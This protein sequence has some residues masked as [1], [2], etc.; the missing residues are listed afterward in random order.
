MMMNKGRKVLARL[1]RLAGQMELM[2]DNYHKVMTAY[3]QLVVMYGTE[4]CWKGE[5]KPGMSG[6]AGELQKL[7]NQEAR[8]VT[9]CFR[10]TNLGALTMESR[11]RPATAQLDNRQR[12]FT[13]QLLSLPAGSEARGIMGAHSAIGRR[14]EA[15][16]GYSGRVEGTEMV[17]RPVKTDAVRIVEEQ[18]RAI[19]EAE[20]DREGLTIFTNGSRLESGATGYGMAWKAGNRWVGVKAHIGYNQEAFDVECAALARVLEVAARRRTGPKAVTIFTDLQAAM[21]RIASEEPGP[22]QRYVRQTREWIKELR[23]RDRNLRIELHWCPA[24]SGATGNEE[25][26]KWAKQVAE[27]PD[28]QGVEWMDYKDRYGRW[29]MPLPRSLANLKQDISEKKW[30]E[31]WMWSKKRVRGRKYLMPK[32][33]H[34]NKLVAQSS[35]RLAGRYHQLRTRHCRTGQ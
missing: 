8:A 25:A 35:K 15:S 12:Q 21:A 10:T 17:S 34:Q 18:K 22:A 4:L 5:G 33:I 11:L 13:A 1:K 26:D 14:L 2:S 32:T 29:S 9:G 24:H 28:A 19:E 30:E 20:K 31:A 27:E 7:V 23:K 6:G 16:I 3:V